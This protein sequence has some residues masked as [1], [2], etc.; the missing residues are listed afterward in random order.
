MSAPADAPSKLRYRPAFD[1]S[2][3]FIL[4][5]PGY[6]EAYQSFPF[7][8]GY[9]HISFEEQRLYD[10]TPSPPMAMGNVGLFTPTALISLRAACSGSGSLRCHDTD[11]LE[12]VDLIT[13]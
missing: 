12:Q 11:L 9:R 4:H 6:S 7:L 2:L 10:M 13:I 1:G 3:P 5:E 8:P